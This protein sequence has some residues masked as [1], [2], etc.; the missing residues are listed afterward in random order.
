[1]CFCW[2]HIPEGSSVLRSRIVNQFN[3][4]IISLQLRSLDVGEM[5]TWEAIV[6][7]VSASLI[8]KSS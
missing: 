7:V 3:S 1:M 2:L 6:C 8:I 5:Q 4:G